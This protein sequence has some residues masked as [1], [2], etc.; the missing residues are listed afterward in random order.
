[1][2]FAVIADLHDNQD[3][4]NKFLDWIKA[5]RIDTVLA[6][7]DLT[8]EEVL[9]KLA[10]AL[11]GKL[12]AIRG[13]A[14]NYEEPPLK[15]PNL[16]YLGRCGVVTLAGQ[17]FGL[18]H[19][20]EYFKEVIAREP[21]LGTIFY[22]HTHKPWLEDKVIAGRPRRLINPGTLGGVNYQATFAVY[23]TAKQAPELINL[24]A[25]SL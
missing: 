5:E 12:F 16:H 20:P 7:G 9:V 14:D 15:L 19:E 11:S 23:D 10:A 24:N 18:C 3:N 8:Q 21:E 1:M 2:R 17:S 13:N 25:I 4:L 6:A 22:G